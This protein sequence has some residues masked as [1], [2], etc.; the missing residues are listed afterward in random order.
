MAALETK[1]PTLIDVVSSM[2][3]SG[4]AM[5]TVELLHQFNEMLAD[6]P[7]I[8]A[9]G[10][11]GHL[12]S[13]RTGLP[14][15]TWR[16]YY[17]GVQPTKSTRAKVTEQMAMLEDYAEVDKALADVNGNAAAFRASEDIAH[18]EGLSNTFATGIIFGNDA[19]NVEQFTGFYPRYNLTTAG[20]GE[21]IIDGGAAGGQ[22][23][24][25]SI[26]LVVWG[27][28]TV[29]G[30]YPKGSVGGIQ[31]RDLGE[32]TIENADGSS[33]RMQAYRTHYKWDCGLC[34]KDWRYVVRIANIDR[35]ALVGDL[36]GGANLPDL[37]S[38]AIERIPSLGSGRAV[39]YMDRS[40]RQIWRKQMATSLKTSTLTESMIGGVSS[41][42]FQGIPIRRMDVMSPD[43][44]IVS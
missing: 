29:F 20:N 33:G 43:E 35:S 4:M 17:G 14:T 37:M 3:P 21:N 26:L 18:I 7:W 40:L 25:A 41:P 38:D 15:P 12:T 22:T 11:T 27:E 16:Q 36:S 5:P 32:V 44:A 8:E 13:V 28:N 34:V 1:W 10:I 19:I 23:D 42:D 6:M 24:C 30:I 2:D 9:N 39:F 31:V